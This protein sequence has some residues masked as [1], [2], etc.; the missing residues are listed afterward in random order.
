[1]GRIYNARIGKRETY[2]GHDH[3]TEKAAKSCG[4]RIVGYSDQQVKVTWSFN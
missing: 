2:C 1:M 3:K 4:R